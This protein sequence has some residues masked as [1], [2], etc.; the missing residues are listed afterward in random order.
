MSIRTS[1]VVTGRY[2]NQTSGEAPDDPHDAVPSLVARVVEPVYSIPAA[3]HWALEQA[4]LAGGTGPQPG[5]VMFIVTSP[6]AA[7]KPP[8]RIST[9]TPAVPVKES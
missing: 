1:P 4:S 3:A 2:L 9:G 8:T 6:V 7:L 5:A